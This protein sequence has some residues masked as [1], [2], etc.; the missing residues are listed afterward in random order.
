[1]T[2]VE[3]AALLG[4]EFEELIGA[5]NVLK[6]A[7]LITIEGSALGLTDVGA[8]IADAI[9]LPEREVKYRYELR[10][11]APALSEG[12]KSRDFCKDMMGM[13]RLWSSKKYRLC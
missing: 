12:G 9:V 4:L 6:T 11:D 3:L 8:R 2:S 5:I 13:G 7:E 1:M 10:P